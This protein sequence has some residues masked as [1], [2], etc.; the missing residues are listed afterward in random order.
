MWVSKGKPDHQQK[1]NIL[2]KKHINENNDNGAGTEQE[3]DW[4]I[5]E[6]QG[7]RQGKEGQTVSESRT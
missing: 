2:N 5:I 6:T 7:T 4:I 1:P 3:K